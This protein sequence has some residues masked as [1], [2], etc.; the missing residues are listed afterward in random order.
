M[1][2]APS[3][4]SC[5]Y[6]A[7]V[8]PLPASLPRSW[9]MLQASRLK[10]LHHHPREPVGT[11]NLY[12]RDPKTLSPKNLN[13]KMQTLKRNSVAQET[14]RTGRDLQDFLVALAA[15]GRPGRSRHVRNAHTWDRGARIMRHRALLPLGP[16]LGHH[17]LGDFDDELV[18]GT[19]N[20]KWPHAQRCAVLLRCSPGKPLA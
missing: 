17:A 12:S 20:P 7:Y 6:S 4:G 13:S 1:C 15:P 18:S 8:L 16:D 14:R 11:V 5:C 9:R 10:N 2:G 19:P 3:P